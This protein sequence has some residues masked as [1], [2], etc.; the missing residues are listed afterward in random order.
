[1]AAC[2]LSH[3]VSVWAQV[4]AA[5]TGPARPGCGGEQGP[6]VEPSVPTHFPSGPGTPSALQL[7]DRQETQIPSLPSAMESALPV[8]EPVPA[9]RS[10]QS[11]RCRLC[12]QCLAER[13]AAWDTLLGVVT[14]HR[15]RLVPT[16]RRLAG[17][18]SASLDGAL[19]TF[20]SDLSVFSLL[21]WTPWGQ[22]F[23]LL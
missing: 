10:P 20:H 9:C 17:P 4:S 2:K 1:M 18:S 11:R 23:S 8:P 19:G 7:S 16:A 14:E 22:G 13:K 5:A 12:T 21:D 3:S 6:D 15:Y